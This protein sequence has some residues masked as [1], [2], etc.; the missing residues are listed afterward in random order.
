MGIKVVVFFAGSQEIH[1]MSY[2]LLTA[3]KCVAKEIWAGNN[4]G[5]TL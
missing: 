5:N 4:S 3:R 2:R 1:L